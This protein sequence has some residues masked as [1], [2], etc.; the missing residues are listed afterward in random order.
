MVA[1][2]I[3][4]A[5]HHDELP[6]VAHRLRQPRPRTEQALE[7]LPVVHSG[8]V[9]HEPRLEPRNCRARRGQRFG[10]GG[11]PR[12]VAPAAAPTTTIRSAGMCSSSAASRAVASEIASTMSAA[13]I[14]SSRARYRRRRPGIGEVAL[15]KDLGDE[16]VERHDQAHAA[17]C[18]GGRPETV[19][20]DLQLERRR[21]VQDPGAVVTGVARDT[22]AVR[23]P[24]ARDE[25]LDPTRR[26]EIGI[27]R[28][29]CARADDARATTPRRARRCSG[30][31]H[32][33]DDRRSAS[34]GRR[35][36][37]GPARRPGGPAVTDRE[38]SSY[39]SSCICSTNAPRAASR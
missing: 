24:A 39:N 35:G 25:R 13:R 36:E 30:R 23:E 22:V 4:H 6:R 27:E 28:E 20:R 15:G 18:R 33:H 34:P 10:S 16:V 5:A 7:V 31:R 9:E 12:V 11:R 17:S 37:P 32:G 3:V 1:R 14:N 29:S 21:D 26:R 19:D 38:R 8:G 2:R